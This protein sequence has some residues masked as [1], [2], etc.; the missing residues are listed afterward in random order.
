LIEGFL[1]T[2]MF[3]NDN[4]KDTATGTELEVISEKLWAIKTRLDEK[5][6]VDREK[7]LRFLPL[8]NETSTQLEIEHNNWLSDRIYKELLTRHPRPT[9]TCSRK[10]PIWRSKE[11][12]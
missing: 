9:L 10:R 11:N 8:M 4:F 6:N 12:R 3:D 7:A 2:L 1:V 5:S